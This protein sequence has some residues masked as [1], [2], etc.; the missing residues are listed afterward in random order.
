MKILKYLFFLI[1]LSGVASAVTWDGLT[2]SIADTLFINDDGDTMTGDLNIGTGGYSSGGITLTTDGGAFVQDL[3]LAGNITNIGG[4]LINGSLNPAAGITATLGNASNSWNTIHGGLLNLTTIGWIGQ[5]QIAVLSDLTAGNLT[6]TVEIEVKNSEPVTMNKGDPV[7]FTSYISG[8]AIQG[9]NFANNT[10]VTKHVDCVIAETIASNARGQC[11]ESGHVIQMDTSGFSLQ[12]DLYLDT[13]GNLSN[14]KQKFANCVQKIGMVLRSHAS[15][16]VIWVN[17]V[18]RCNDIPSVLNATGNVSF[19]QL[20]NCDTI[21]T[22]DTGLLTC[23]DDATGAG[24]ATPINITSVGTLNI[25]GN[26]SAGGLF[27]GSG[28]EANQFIYFYEDGSS[29]GEWMNWNDGEDSFSVSDRFIMLD[30]GHIVNNLTI[31]GSLYLGG[32]GPSP[33][34]IFVS[35]TINASEI[36][37]TS[38]YQDG[39]KVNDSVMLDNLILDTGDILSGYYNQ[40]SGNWSMAEN[41]THC[42]G[43]SCEGQIY[44]NGSSLVIKVT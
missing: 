3:I 38:F 43:W 40:T 32:F 33:K 6:I 30:S 5:S 28:V 9:V 8:L 4:V 21:N 27:I 34:S 36:N 20:I 1:V 2:R 25:T 39:N 10:D 42:Y 37:A 35:G 16:G 13:G 31:D 7:Y 14:E 11:V 18:D 29:T 23:G 19:Q 41:G 44:Y 24:D 26:F 12:D 15:Q 17:G 22:D